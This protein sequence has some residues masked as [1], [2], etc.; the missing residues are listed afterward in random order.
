MC[1]LSGLLLSWAEAKN[2]HVYHSFGA[3]DK[4]KPRVVMPAHAF[5][6]RIVVTPSGKT[7][8]S[9]FEPLEEGQVSIDYRKRQTPGD[10]MSTKQA[11]W[12]WNINDTYSM[13]FFTSNVDLPNWSLLDVPQLQGLK[14]S[15]L[16]G[17]SIL[18]FVMYENVTPKEKGPYHLQQYL[19]YSYA[20]Q[21]KFLG[22]Q[23][24]QEGISEL[25][26]TI[27]DWAT[28]KEDNNEK[29]DALQLKKAESDK[30]PSEERAKKDVDSDRF[31]EQEDDCDKSEEVISKLP[32][33]RLKNSRNS[34]ISLAIC[35]ILCPAWIE[36][37][38][39]Q[40]KYTRAYA[41]NVNN[42]TVFRTP[43]SFRDLLS[44]KN[45][46]A[47]K[48]T[49]AMM[50]KLCSPRVS[51]A[52]RTRRMFGKMLES[53]LKGQ[54]AEMLKRMMEI[55]SSQFLRTRDTSWPT[56]KPKPS[57]ETGGIVARALSD[58]HWVEEWAEITKTSITFSQPETKNVHLSIKMDCV[59]C[60][61]CVEDD[62]APNFR[63][64]FFMAV[65]TLGRTTYIMFATED[66]RRECFT[67][68]SKF[69]SSDKLPLFLNTPRTEFLQQS[70]LWNCGQRLIMNNRQLL[71]RTPQPAEQLDPL[72]LVEEALTQAF[73]EEIER[74]DD[75]LQ[76]F[77]DSVSK[78]KSVNTNDLK[79]ERRIA[80]FLNLYHV[81][82]RHSALIF[83]ASSSQ[84]TLVKNYMCLSYQCSDDIFSIG[85]LEH[86]ILR[87]Q[88]T[89]LPPSV[90]STNIQAPP[91]INSRLLKATSPLQM[92]PAETFN[93]PTPTSSYCFALQKADFRICFALTCGSKSNLDHIPIYTAQMLNQQLDETCKEFL[94][95]KVGIK[96]RN[97]YHVCVLPRVCQWYANDFGETNYAVLKTLEPYLEQAEQS[98][99]HSA[100]FAKF[101]INIKYLPFSF[102]NR[103]V[104]LKLDQPH[105][106]RSKY[107]DDDELRSTQS[108]IYSQST[109]N[110]STHSSVHSF[111]T[112][113]GTTHLRIVDAPPVID[114]DDMDSLLAFLMDDALEI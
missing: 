75:K 20:V 13:A 6:D 40:G 76:V 88:M 95:G 48:I 25:N 16:I 89:Q 39:P 59:L 15:N 8:P 24:R 105:F 80:F 111:V 27:L 60:I 30:F 19:R 62:E 7:P 9:L 90:S 2:H 108:G 11:Q 22:Q 56:I 47:D 1:R 36:M 44:V 93:F 112:T 71:F 38:A 72:K 110:S 31:L 23:A 97:K 65:E 87:A 74:D 104:T 82:M 51:G 86:N 61:R 99:L 68:I 14:L 55:Y 92:I 37:C 102:Q 21:C 91:P 103:R 106:R 35:D 49:D 83:G 107:E 28:T 101:P 77:L 52:E 58:R 98:I 67:S 69:I 81:M 78:L 100:D 12:T 33:L 18:R 57:G 43:Q 10:A 85:E 41:F 94:K 3:D 34:F 64:Y 45:Y 84:A 26:D 63:N 66:D 46:L 42:R 54:N 53:S 113:K 73:D 29:N 17:N 70:S 50:D 96:Q 109:T 4:E 114:N 32:D 79:E 5:F